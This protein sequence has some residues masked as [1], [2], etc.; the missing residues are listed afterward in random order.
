M[1]PK[2]WGCYMHGSKYSAKKNSTNNEEPL[3]KFK[4]L[5]SS[6]ELFYLLGNVSSLP[7]LSVHSFCNINRIL[8][9]SLEKLERK[10]NSTLTF[11]HLN[12]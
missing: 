12:I 4:C 6:Q 3:Q 11:W 5:L 8:L 7:S 2:A 9:S 10:N 1:G